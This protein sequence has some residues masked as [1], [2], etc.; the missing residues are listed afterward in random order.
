[1]Y[2]AIAQDK[3]MCYWGR[4]A[5][6]INL[7][8]VECETILQLQIALANMQDR[9][10]MIHVRSSTKLPQESARRMV[11]IAKGHHRWFEPNA[12]RKENQ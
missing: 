1:M 7:H 12:F 8:V 11:S 2:Y 3:F 4:A 5:G 10:D 9:D 6:K